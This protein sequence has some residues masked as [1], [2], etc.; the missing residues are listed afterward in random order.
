M[1]TLIAKIENL[2]AATFVDSTAK[3]GLDKPELTIYGKFDEGKKEERVSF[4]RQGQDVYAAKAGE[5][6]AATVST[7]EFDDTLKVLDEVSK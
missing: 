5:P 2:R 3:T 7:A 6:G 1:D 4:A